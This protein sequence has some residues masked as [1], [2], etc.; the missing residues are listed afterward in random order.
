MGTHSV[1]IIGLFI[2]S[3]ISGMLGLGVAFAAIPFLGLFLPD[4]VHQVQPLSL[5]LN[6]VTALFSVFGFARGGHMKWKKAL[7]LAAVTTV[8][9]PFGAW[10]AH[11]V[12]QL[13]LWGIYFVAVGYLAYR[14][15]R[16]I[17]EKECCTE[18]FTLALILAV[19][20]S[21]LAGLLGVGPGFLLMPTLMLVGF[22]SKR[23]AAINA[24]AV[25]PPSFSAL[26]P[27]LGTAQVD[28]SLAVPLIVVGAVGSFFGAR[29][30]SRYVP[31]ARIKQIFAILILV[32]TLYKIWTLL[33]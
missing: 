7:I 5:I 4:L 28:L 18:N 11:Y 23:A 22:E 20:I 13:L 8:V 2:L 29:M 6:G 31:S 30:T 26:I 19:P 32:T 3:I 15:F 25:M 10:L 33:G 21:V 14:L 17:Q 9:A 16:P 27:H 1:I 24:F 12:D